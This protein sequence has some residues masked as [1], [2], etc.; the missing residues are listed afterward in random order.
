MEARYRKE[1]ERLYLQMY[2]MLFEYAR[3]ALSNDALAEEAVQ[4]TFQIAC[5]KP[6]DLFKSPNP[7]GWL[8]KVLKYV[9]LNTRRN[10]STAVRILS[11]YAA[12]NA[13]EKAVS[14]DEID[15]E[16][17]YGNVAKT[18]EFKLLKEAALEE[19]S[20]LEMAEKRGITVEAC[21]KRLQRAKEL[22]KRKIRF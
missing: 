20:H 15:L 21:K 14:N 6:E 5:Q 7:K 4:D 12:I 18:E 11:E 16:T 10:Q 1:I 22:L 9:I 19:L 8:V 13:A 2:P 17:L 3:S